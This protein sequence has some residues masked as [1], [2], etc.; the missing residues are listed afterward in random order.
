MKS[1]DGKKGEKSGESETSEKPAQSL[2]LEG[3][4]AGVA[5]VNDSPVGCQSRDLTEPA[6][7]T[8][9]AQPPDEAGQTDQETP[10][11]LCALDPF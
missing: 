9:A 3:S 8:A 7:E 6:G 4:K 1:I 10:L 5:V 2:P 11:F